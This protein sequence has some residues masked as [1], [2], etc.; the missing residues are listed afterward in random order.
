MK[1]YLYFLTC[2]YVFLGASAD[3]YAQRFDSVGVESP[4]PSQI[5][6]PEK[7]LNFTSLKKKYKGIDSHWLELNKQF[8][9]HPDA[10]YSGPDV[11]EGE[12][13]EILSKR[14]ESSRF[15]VSA[16]NPS[17]VHS[18]GA[19]G[20][21][22][23]RKDNQWLVIDHRLARVADGIY[24]ANRQ[25]VP[26]GLDIHK[27]ITYIHTAEGKVHFN[28]WAMFG[29]REGKAKKKIAE[30]DWSN[31]TIGDDGVRVVDIFPGIDAEMVTGRGSIKTSFIVK[32][33]FENSF[34]EVIL[35]DQ[36]Q[37]GVVPL[38]FWYDGQRVSEGRVSGELLMKKGRN[39]VLKIGKAFMYAAES[40]ANVTDLVYL[41]NDQELGINIKTSEIKDLLKNGN[42]IID[43]LVDGGEGK[44]DATF[45]LNSYRNPDFNTCENYNFDQACS[46][47]WTVPVPADVQVI[48]TSHTN[49]LNVV[50]PCT[51]DKMGFRI[52][53][54]DERNC[55]L[56]TL[57]ISQG[58]PDTPGVVG[59]APNII[60]N[61]NNCI[62][63]KC[64][65]YDL[66]VSLA[67]IRACVGP[68]EC[69]SSCVSGTGPF[70][71]TITGRTL[72]MITMESS[73]DLSLEICP[74]EPLTLTPVAEFGVKPYVYTW[75]DGQ[76]DPI[77]TVRPSSNTSYS[78]E[79]SDA[80]QNKVTTKVDVKVK[81][82]TAPPSLTIAN[83][84]EGIVCPGIELNW[85][86]SISAQGNY[87]YQWTV[88]G[89]AVE[90]ADESD[91]SV[92]NLTNRDIVSLKATINESCFEP[93]EVTSNEIS[94][95]IYDGTLIEEVVELVG[96]DSLTYDGQVYYESGVIEKMILSTTGC[97][98]LRQIINIDI[99]HFEL[100]LTALT[101]LEVNE[102]E[103]IH[104]KAEANVPDFYISHWEPASLFSNR[105]LEKQQQISVLQT[106][107]FVVHGYSDSHCSSSD[108]LLIKVNPAS[109]LSLMPTAFTPN[110]DQVNDVWIPLRLKDF[111]EGKMFVYNRWGQ[112]V[113]HA[114]DYSIPWDGT[115]QGSPVTAGV[116]SYRL[117]IP[118]RKEILGFVTVVY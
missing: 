35:T 62:P 37:E 29:I 16:D 77:R 76:S 36:F 39:T 92:S 2:V 6:V 3:L 86:S 50:A 8:S 17:I 61:Y 72:E 59:G 91:W 99:E 58:R 31:I 78:V 34:D 108:T 103:L 20:P 84:Q 90:G 49:N 115:Y 21:L 60:T 56:G 32:E 48:T 81:I 43:P 89:T 82:P 30:A 24:E 98:S 64:E 54:G 111:P 12:V 93:Y 42:V 4:Q 112:C 53:L 74:G 41:I 1:K 22:H 11:P 28:Q 44:L 88:N 57:W 38:S 23:Y 106:E 13:I 65:D 52:V 51:R 107:V 85:Q 67:I 75:S 15:F 40:P 110:G 80:C 96:C 79:I 70:I 47:S 87:G 117:V 55:G 5:G 97:D 66:T 63:V 71:M 25:P 10:G 14:T 95:V 100:H 105:P 102:K 19:L 109:N 114:Q 118:G 18:Q 101:P 73:K 45:P 83:D 113:Y 69:E 94:A 7:Q 46:Y 33:W 116:Y 27:A 104:L 68:R 26:T 9:D